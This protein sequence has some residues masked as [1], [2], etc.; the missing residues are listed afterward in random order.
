M[1]SERRSTNF[2][3]CRHANK[4]KPSLLQQKTRDT[5]SFDGSGSHRGAPSGV[6]A[7]YAAPMVDPAGGVKNLQHTGASCLMSYQCALNSLHER[8]RLAGL[9]QSLQVSFSMKNEGKHLK[10]LVKGHE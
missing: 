1:R 10:L 7:V 9:R 6:A 5:K 8:Y 3:T 4:N 2:L